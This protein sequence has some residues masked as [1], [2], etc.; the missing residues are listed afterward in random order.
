MIIFVV[1]KADMTTDCNVIGHIVHE[2]RQN[3]ETESLAGFFTYI[4]SFL[5]GLGGID[6]QASADFHYT[7]LC[8]RKCAG[9][10]ESH[11]K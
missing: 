9:Y 3:G 7:L 6:T 1:A 10:T 11:C 4:A 2:R 8:K 5:F